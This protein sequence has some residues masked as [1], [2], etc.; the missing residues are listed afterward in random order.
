MSYSLLNLKGLKM[1][2][3][4]DAC[5]ICKYKE[6]CMGLASDGY[7]TWYTPISVDDD[8][9]SNYDVYNSIHNATI[10]ENNDCNCS[11]FEVVDI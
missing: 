1:S 7:Y 6:I 2:N 9:A 10:D 8:L 3:L 5:S 4:K 11:K